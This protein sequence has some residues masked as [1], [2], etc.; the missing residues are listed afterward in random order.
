MNTTDY[1]LG[2]ILLYYFGLINVLL[3]STTYVYY[4][5]KNKTSPFYSLSQFAAI[6]LFVSGYINT[7]ILLC[8]IG[9]CYGLLHIKKVLMVI[10]LCS[11]AYN[12]ITEIDTTTNTNKEISQ[13]IRVI[14]YVKEKTKFINKGIEFYNIQ[15]TECVE[16]YKALQ[17][18]N[19]YNY[20]N[21]FILFCTRNAYKL[22]LLNDKYLNIVITEITSSS[23]YNKYRE[24]M[25]NKIPIEI[26]NMDN[27]YKEY[28]KMMQKNNTMVIPNQQHMMD[29]MLK[30]MEMMQSMGNDKNFNKLLTTNKN[31]NNLQMP[32]MENIME[33]VMKDMMGHV[34]TEDMGNLKDN[35]LSYSDIN[36][37]ND[38]LLKTKTDH[39]L[40][41]RK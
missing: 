15:K 23:V 38:F 3:C 26:R 11:L 21:N 34:K 16:V 6:I 33:T 17:V 2:V 24:R 32:N 39:K 19:Y 13:I 36:N 8:Q 14:N 18:H 35:N 10:N 7:F 29:D 40:K 30:S 4:N 41:K 12:K 28:N 5:E 25:I 31:T 20:T 22:Y 37:L 27:M 9:V 1:I